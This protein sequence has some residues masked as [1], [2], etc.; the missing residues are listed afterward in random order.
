MWFIWDGCSCLAIEGWIVLVTGVHEEASEEDV[1]DFFAE[2]GEIQ[3][4]HLNLDRRTG[5]VKVSPIPPPQPSSQKHR[6]LSPSVISFFS[7]YLF[8]LGTMANPRATPSSNMQPSKKQKPPLR[9]HRGKKFL[10]NL[11]TLTLRLFVDPR[12]IGGGDLLV[13]REV[14]E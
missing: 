4:T 1:T 13:L 12:R 5:Y 14:V 2:F 11:F 7:L 6:T 8:Y 9:E 3:Q 10:T